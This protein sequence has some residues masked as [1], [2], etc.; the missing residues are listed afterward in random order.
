MRHVKQFGERPILVRVLIAVP[1]AFLIFALGA[2]IVS[3]VGKL[4]DSFAALLDVPRPQVQ[5]H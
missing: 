4:T 2:L 1:A 5:V 3:G